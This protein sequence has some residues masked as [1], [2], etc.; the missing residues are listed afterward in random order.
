MS[1]VPYYDDGQVIL[2]CTDFRAVEVPAGSVAAVVTSPPYNV[3]LDYHDGDDALDWP[4][5]WARAAHAAETIAGSVVDGGRV[6]VNTAVSVPTGT[7]TR[8]KTRVMLAFRWAQALENAGLSLVDQVAWCSARGAGTAWGS[9]ASPA[10]PNLRGDW[11]SLLVACAG[12][13]ERTAPPCCGEDWRDTVGGWESLCST[14]WHLS[15]ARRDGH[16]APFPIG[17]AHRAIRLSTWPDEVVFDPFA[18]S[19]TTLLAARQLGRR[20]VGIERSE[21]YCEL[22]AERLAQTTLDFRG[23]A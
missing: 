20:A 1:V 3:G 2:Y 7:E 14:V 22:A 10:A 21:R 19:G 5:Y 8:A 13:W 9:W 15:P 11:E 12:R 18:G 17:L 6:W 23:A 4:T 16:P